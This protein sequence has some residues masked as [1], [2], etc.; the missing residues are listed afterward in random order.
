MLRLGY[1]QLTHTGDRGQSDSERD[2]VVYPGGEPDLYVGEG[3]SAVVVEHG[4][5]CS[6][7]VDFYPGHIERPDAVVPG[8]AG[9][10]HRARFALRVELDMGILRPPVLSPVEYFNETYEQVPWNVVPQAALSRTVNVYGT[11]SC[12]RI[13]SP[14][15]RACQDAGGVGLGHGRG[16]GG[17][18]EPPEKPSYDAHGSWSF[19]LEDNDPNIIS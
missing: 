9:D 14:H 7:G 18:V 2:V 1:D 3:Y 16:R 11:R 6:G 4:V 10:V 12:Q 17:F 8:N 15:Q 19:L 13:G 5:R